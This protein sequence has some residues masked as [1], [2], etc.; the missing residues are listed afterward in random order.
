MPK[1][2]TYCAADR[3]YRVDIGWNREAG[4]VEISVKTDEAIGIYSMADHIPDSEQ[5]GTRY[6]GSIAW[7]GLHCQLDRAGINDLIRTLRRARDQAF[8][9]DE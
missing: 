6:E 1:E 3:H 4:H 8:G 7:S 2:T 9:R 5:P